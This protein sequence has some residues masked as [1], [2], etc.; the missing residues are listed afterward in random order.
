VST[1]AQ[2]FR[3]EQER[4]KP[5]R[6]KQVRKPRL[7]VGTHLARGAA[8]ATMHEHTGAKG[9]TKATVVIEESLSGKSSRKSTRA[10]ANKQKSGAVLE[11][12]RQM[13]SATA[14]SRHNRRGG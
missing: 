8:N 1:R 9:A 3:S 5:P 2:Q 14:K 7:N 6:P 11:H 10:S 12:V 4:S 13:K